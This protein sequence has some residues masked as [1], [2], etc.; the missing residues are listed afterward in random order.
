[1]KKKIIICIVIYILGIFTPILWKTITKKS[2]ESRVIYDIVI[3]REF[4]NLR[5][6]VDLSKKPVRKVFKG[7]RYQV[8]DYYEGNVYN[9][10]KVIYDE[11]KI[12]FIASSKETSWVIIEN[13]K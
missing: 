11:N 9:W 5:N 10:Y 7:E 4:I 3:D 6:E 12:G 8:I 1:M 2:I 13:E